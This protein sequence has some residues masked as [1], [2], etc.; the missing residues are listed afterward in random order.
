MKRQTFF[1]LAAV[2]SLAGS[3]I[4]Y[5]AQA[6]VPTLAY[7]AVDFLKPPLNMPIGE[8]AGVATNSKGHV[9]IYERSG[10]FNT[11][12]GTSRTFPHGSSKLLQF[13]QNGKFVRE[14]GRDIYAFV[15][16]QS[17]RID[18]QDN[19]WI[20]D[21]YANMAVKFDPEGRVLMTFG[22]RPETSRTPNVTLAATTPA[23]G[24]APAAARGAGGRGDGGAAP[25]AVARGAVPPVPGAQGGR[26]A[27]PAAGGRGAGAA[28]DSFNRPTD[29]AWDAAGN[30]FIA[31]GFQGNTPRIL[32]M[33][34]N[35][36]FLK[37]FGG[38]GTEPGQFNSIAS[39]A[40]DARGNLYVADKGNNRIQVLDNDGNPK[41]Q[42]A[43]IGTPAAIC[44]SSGAH[45]YLYSSN[46]NTPDDLDHGEIYK[47][48]LD[49]TVLG[50]FGTAGH[51]VREFG[52]VNAIDCRNENVL[53][54]GELINWRVQKLTMKK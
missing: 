45:Q 20:V 44:I 19:I 47:M 32:K 41:A 31:D 12:V 37:T 2:M 21:Q 10:T 16:A 23:A 1:A 13:D 30:I 50:K 54:V 40:V 27:A 11:T 17:V 52:S 4:A 18:P 53:Y 3:A 38:R 9:F 28:G 46:S 25:A 43:N 6:T 36:R 29:V 24:A 5:V 51:L 7:D 8:V 22:R 26:G 39:I 33:D 34:K 14:L 35:G 42:Y 48:E 49:G 15:Y